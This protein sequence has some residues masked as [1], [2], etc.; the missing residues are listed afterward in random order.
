MLNHERCFG[1]VEL[2]TKLKR[3]W[4]WRTFLP[5]RQVNKCNTANFRYTS[6]S[7][8]N[9]YES[10]AASSS[11]GVHFRFWVVS[12]RQSSLSS[13]NGMHM[14]SMGRPWRMGQCWG[15]KRRGIPEK[16][17]TPILRQPFSTVQEDSQKTAAAMQ[18]HAYTPVSNSRPGKHSDVTQRDVKF[19]V[20]WTLSA[21][22]FTQL[23]HNTLDS[24]T[25]STQ[26][27]RIQEF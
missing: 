14:N 2:S 17:R 16:V 9:T 15:R 13:R 5:M 12:E 25:C 20:S 21:M 4:I 3:H 11:W 22:S 10:R 8:T 26:I 6:P 27:N 23:N 19:S 7:V 24:P 18:N 1:Y